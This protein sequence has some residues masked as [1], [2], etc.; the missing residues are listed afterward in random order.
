MS[1]VC[2][3]FEHKI[4]P[5]QAN[6]HTLNLAIHWEEYKLRVPVQPEPIAARA[7]S[8][9]LLVSICSS[10]IGGVN[11]HAVLE[12][13]SRAERRPSSSS[14]AAL[15]IAGGLSPR[16]AA[17]IGDDIQKLVAGLSDEE[18]VD[19]SVVY[20]RRARQM[21]WHSFAV[22]RP[23]HDSITFSQPVLAPRVK[24]PVVFLFSG[25]GPQHLHSKSLSVYFIISSH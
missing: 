11:A 22:K 4:V 17:T 14:S 8:G 13:F 3:I 10:G 23:G 12:S 1:K 21:T 2:S 5:P 19:Y 25:Q 7:S 6:L 16:S 20:G 18:V 15:L 9:N 24:P